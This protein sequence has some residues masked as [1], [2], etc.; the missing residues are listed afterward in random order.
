VVLF[1]MVV[2]KPPFETAEVKLTYD[3]IRKGLYSFPEQIKLSDDVKNIITKIF[4]LDPSKRPS[5]T[6]IMEH[7][8]LNNGVGVAKTMHISTLAMKPNK[9]MIESIIGKDK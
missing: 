3:K 4:V 7:P 8:F 6:E 2:G 9:S 1:A 5:L